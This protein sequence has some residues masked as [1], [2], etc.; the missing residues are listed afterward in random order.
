MATKNQNRKTLHLEDII[1]Q[2]E[3]VQTAIAAGATGLAY[4][5]ESL[6]NQLQAAAQAMNQFTGQQAEL[7]RTEIQAAVQL[8]HGDMQTDI[9]ETRRIQ[10]DAANQLNSASTR[11]EN[12]I[13]S[14]FANTNSLIDRWGNRI[15]SAVGGEEFPV[16]SIVM[17]FVSMIAGIISGIAVGKS[18]ARITTKL[19]DANGGIVMKAGKAVETVKYEG[20]EVAII[21]ICT[22]IVTAIVIYLIYKAIAKII[23]TARNN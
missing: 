2:I 19:Y 12:L 15:L 7:T 22:G 8:L 1:E 23:S 16:A 9:S 3:R 20:L 13:N 21:G 11:L 17:I 10:Q 6:A 4:N 5:S 14:Q 18:F